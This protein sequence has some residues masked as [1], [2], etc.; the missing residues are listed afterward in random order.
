MTTVDA[1]GDRQ[2]GDADPFFGFVVGLFVAALVAPVATIGVA[3]AAT[4]D[5]GV[6]FFTFLGVGVAAIAVGWRAAG[7]EAVAVRLGGTRRA[8]LAP[9]AGL[10]YAGVLLAATDVE[11]PA[12]GIAV[13][14][15]VLGL[16][17]GLVGGAGLVF[18]AH[19]RHARA[20]LDGSDRSVE[21]SARGPERDRRLAT[22]G[23]GALML[24]GTIGFA[25]S[26]AVGLE[27][28]RWL[29]HFMI[30]GGAG[31]AGATAERTYVVANAG[32]RVGTPV[33][34]RIRPWSVFDGHS[35]T[36]DALVLHRSGWSLRGLRDLRLDRDEIEDVETIR[37]VLDE[38]LPRR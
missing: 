14:L 13:G 10:A 22:W 32:V 2:T 6:L 37:S 19:N 21:F 4:T 18:A 27:P 11:G 26:L 34:K 38:H 3:V 5:A 7:R 23:V 12:S 17:G 33:H 1:R 20:A 31:L 16:I 15:A 36:D 35:L 30:A 24:S 25:A 8:W 28:L 9:A 29:F